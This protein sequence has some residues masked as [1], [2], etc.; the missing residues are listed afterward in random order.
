MTPTE[1]VT[2]YLGAFDGG[3]PDAIADMV[4]ADF[5]NEHTSSL[6]ETLQGRETYRARL[7]RFLT[8]FTGLRYDAERIIADGSHVAVPYLLTATWLGPAGDR[9][10]ISIRGMFHFEVEG[11]VIV[12]RV[13]YWDSSEFLRQTGQESGS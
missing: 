3:D 1:V 6:G 2:A 12:R 13:D 10:P 7:V 4:S 5:V 11:G 8:D 9:H